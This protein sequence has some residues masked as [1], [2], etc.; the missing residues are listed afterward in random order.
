MRA[1][2]PVEAVLAEAL[3]LPL[4]GQAAGCS[5]REL[6]LALERSADRFLAVEAKGAAAAKTPSLAAMETICCAARA[7][8]TCSSAAPATTSCAETAAMTH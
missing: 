4:P 3:L 2:S 1:C 5:I 7:A 6:V 8:M